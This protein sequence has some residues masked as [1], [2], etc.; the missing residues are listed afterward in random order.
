LQSLVSRLDE[1]EAENIS[2]REENRELDKLRR[3]NE[4]LELENRKMREQ[5]TSKD[6]IIKQEHLIEEIGILEG[7]IRESE[8]SAQ[9]SALAL[10]TERVH[11]ER[12]LREFEIRSNEAKE[13][14]NN[15]EKLRL[16]IVNLKSEIQDR[17]A[18]EQKLSRK[19]RHYKV[20][21][22]E[23][24]SELISKKERLDDISGLLFRIREKEM[25][26]EAALR[27]KW[28]EEDRYDQERRSMVREL[29]CEK[30]KNVR[31]EMVLDD[32]RRRLSSP[33]RNLK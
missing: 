32:Y 31:M 13:K 6:Y 10:E 28:R 23:Q 4:F 11:F 15:E 3:R 5:P 24:E 12:R 19:Y 17:E 2:L 7:R 14:Q 8:A 33:L 1:L 16:E 22:K 21:C 18:R 29:E 30:E 26:K 9:E 20:K 27:R 25:M